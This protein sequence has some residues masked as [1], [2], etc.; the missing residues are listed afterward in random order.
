MAFCSSARGKIRRSEVF[1]WL[2]GFILMNIQPVF[3]YIAL[4]KLTP[5]IVAALSG[6]NI[7]FT[8]VL[9]YFLLGEHIK[10]SKIPWIGLLALSLAYAGLSGHEAVRQF[11]AEAFWLLPFL[12]NCLCHDSAV[13]E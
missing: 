8:I 2:T 10:S 9:S 12:S 7:I 3:N 11:N 6:S 13:C 5:N 1:G 4:E